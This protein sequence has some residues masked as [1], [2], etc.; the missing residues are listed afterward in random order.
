MDSNVICCGRVHK[1]GTWMLGCQLTWWRYNVEKGQS[2]WVNFASSDIFGKAGKYASKETCWIAWKNVNPLKSHWC[3]ACDRKNGWGNKQHNWIGSLKSLI[4]LYM[5]ISTHRRKRRHAFVVIWK[6][7]IF[8]EQKSFKGPWKEMTFT[9]H[10]HVVLWILFSAD[11]CKPD[12]DSV[13]LPDPLTRSAYY[14]CYKGKGYR[15][16]CDRN[17]VFDQAQS[18]CVN[19]WEM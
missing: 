11:P 18:M 7:L 4:C 1:Q 17:K 9:R 3:I 6:P 8:G 19:P 2:S 14:V 13:I 15:D 12:K 5:Q 16:N 10:I